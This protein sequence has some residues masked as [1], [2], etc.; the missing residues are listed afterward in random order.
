MSDSNA[1]FAVEYDECLKKLKIKISEL[2]LEITPDS[3]TT[4]IKLAMEFV[5]ASKLKGEAQ[6]KL[7]TKIVRKVVVDAPIADEKEKLLLD[8]I[9]QGVVG[10]VIELVVSASKGEID[11][12]S[13]VKVAAGCCA[14]F[15]K[16]R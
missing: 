15:L 13:A 8:M 11:I 16:R 5:E 7:V 1:A 9:D 2:N 14:S 3:I 12:N 4:V 10:N 6:K